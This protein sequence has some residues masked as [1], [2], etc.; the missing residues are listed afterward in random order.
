VLAKCVRSSSLA[1]L[2]ACFGVILLLGFKNFPGHEKLKRALLDRLVIVN[3]LKNCSSLGNTKP[4]TVLYVLGGTQTSLMY[5]FKLAADL[6]H[7]G[8]GE[9]IILM[10]EPGI[11]EYD[12]LLDRNLSNDE[13]AIRWLVDLKVP[14][15]NIEIVV[16]KRG[17][18]GTLSEAK[19][20]RAL[21]YERNYTHIILVTSS[22]HTRRTMTTFSRVFNDR[23]LTLSVYGVAEPIG[24]RGEL[25]EY[26]KLLLYERFIL[27]FYADWQS[28]ERH[29]GVSTE[30]RLF[31]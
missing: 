2:I 15:K 1:V 27:P 4:G 19:G 12:P 29:L 21:A 18:F 10:S 26:M 16:M 20:M 24:L 3:A 7:R 22:F 31:A 11:T 23:G 25:Y 9:K 6:Y 8:V 14:Q 5:K 30:M 17:F 13:W 28:K